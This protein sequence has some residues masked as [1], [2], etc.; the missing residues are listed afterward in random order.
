MHTGFRKVLLGGF[1][2]LVAAAA[3]P[4]GAQPGLHARMLEQHRF[5]EPF[6]A[7]PGLPDAVVAEAQAWERVWARPGAS[8][9]RGARGARSDLEVIGDLPSWV[10]AGINGLRFDVMT[11]V[12]YF[13][14]EMDSYGDIEY[15]HG[16]GGAASDELITAAHAEG[17]RVLVT[18]TN[19]SSSSLDTLLSSPANRANA[20]ATLVDE[21]LDGGGDG[22]DV[23]F[24][25]MSSGNKQDLV[26][27]MQELQAALEAA[28]PNPWI[29]LATPAVDWSGAYDYDELMYAS[30]GLFIMGYGYHWSGGD[31]GPNAP[32]YGSNLWGS[33]SLDWTLAD[34]GVLRT[35]LR[36]LPDLDAPSSSPD[37]RDLLEVGVSVSEDRIAGDNGIPPRWHHNLG[38]T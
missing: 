12:N 37:L 32:K 14:L 25:G 23:D 10:D 29:T 31:P 3:G 7:G 38:T 2:A 28:M 4:S 13:S 24:E 9:T 16:W 22:V 5:D 35:S 34:E 11:Q 18:V 1:A 33:Y 8:R 17:C 26:D 36:V 19:F 20:V 27:F 30:N 15:S 21:V 6:A